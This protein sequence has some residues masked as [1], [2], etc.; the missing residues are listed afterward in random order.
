MNFWKYFFAG[1]ITKVIVEMTIYKL[2]F[3]QYNLFKHFNWVSLFSFS[4]ETIF[5]AA[6]YIMVFYILTNFS[7]WKM[8]VKYE[9][10]QK[11]NNLD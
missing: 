4:L 7:T 3:F 6:I 11:K 8:R 10:A 5:F 9:L 1:I 2:D